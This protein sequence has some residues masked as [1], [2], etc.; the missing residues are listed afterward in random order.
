MAAASCGVWSDP[1]ILRCGRE[2][3]ENPEDERDLNVTE[4]VEG[5]HPDGKAG[6]RSSQCGERPVVISVAD[7]SRRSSEDTNGP[8][9]EPDPC[10]EPDEANIQGVVQPLVVEDRCVSIGGIEAG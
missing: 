7:R 5:E 2:G 4:R 1:E 9:K 10:A 8:H 3:E 6:D